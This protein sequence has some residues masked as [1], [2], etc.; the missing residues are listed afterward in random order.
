LAFLVWLV[1]EEVSVIEV[2]I[3][4]FLFWECLT[5]K[6]PVFRLSH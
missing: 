4:P 3:V 2:G 5:N 6:I 1:Y